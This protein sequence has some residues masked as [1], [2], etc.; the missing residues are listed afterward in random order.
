[1]EPKHSAFWRWLDT[2]SHHSLTLWRLVPTRWAKKPIISR[3]KSLHLQWWNNSNYSIIFCHLELFRP[4]IGALQHH[5]KAIL[6]FQFEIFSAIYRG[7]IYNTIYNWIR[8]PPCRDLKSPYP[9]S[10]LKDTTGGQRSE[11]LPGAVGR[12]PGLKLDQWKKPKFYNCL[13]V[14]QADVL[15]LKKSRSRFKN[16]GLAV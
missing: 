4:F 13:L 5:C 16:M 1:M 12:G 3:A 15:W 6:W 11:D 9:Y 7:P 14:E 2:P 10:F 8:G